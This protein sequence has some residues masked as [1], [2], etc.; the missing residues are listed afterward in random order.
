M[1]NQ[2]RTGIM[3]PREISRRWFLAQCGIGLGSVALGQLLGETGLAAA[4]AARRRSH[5]SQGAPLRAQGQEGHLSLHG[6]GS[7]PPGTAGSQAS[8]DPVRRDHAARRAARG[9]PGGLHR[10]P[11]HAAGPQVQVQPPW[12]KQCRNFGGA[13]PPWHCRRRHCHRQIHEHRCLQPRPRPDPDEHRIPA[14]RPAQP[15]V[16]DHLRPGQRVP[17]PAVLRGL[18]L[19]QQGSQR[20]QCLL[21]E[22]LPAHRPPGRD[23]SAT[24]ASP[25]SIFPIPRVSTPA[26]RGIL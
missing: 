18:Q 6:R 22:R 12:P 11:F 15:G 9:L 7:Q 21:G 16:L 13:A 19:G 17:G 26:C 1:S 10:P 24:P 3:D 5:G 23:L 20:R 2:H 4:R 25:C 8:T 14:V